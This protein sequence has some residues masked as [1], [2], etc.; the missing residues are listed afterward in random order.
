MSLSERG[1]HIYQ[2]KIDGDGRLDIIRMLS[3]KPHKT[4]E[5]TIL[6]VT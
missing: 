2:V 3:D 5:N 4:T 6:H 1:G